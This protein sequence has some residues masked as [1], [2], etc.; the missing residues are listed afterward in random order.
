VTTHKYYYENLDD[1][2]AMLADKPDGK[3][4]ILVGT[5]GNG[6]DVPVQLM[7]RIA[8]KSRALAVWTKNKIQAGEFV[9][10]VSAKA[11]LPQGKLI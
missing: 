5:D 7:L 4:E 9:I 3:L 10:K 2:V 6:N 1:L 11:D 8:V